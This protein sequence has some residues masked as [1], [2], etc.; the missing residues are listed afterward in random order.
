MNTKRS[1]ALFDIDKTIYNQH[2]FFPAAKFL[3]EKGVFT[4]ET[5]PRIESEL[6][7]YNSKL[8]EYS[9]TANN[10]QLWHSESIRIGCYSRK[11]CG[12]SIRSTKNLC[13][14]HQAYSP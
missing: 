2:S 3:I 13:R 4:A 5:W 11:T 7:K 6:E 9:I 8:Q 12:N 14:Y 10:L 1:I